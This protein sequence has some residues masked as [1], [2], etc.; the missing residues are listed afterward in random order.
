M[1]YKKTKPEP[2][3]CPV[4]SENVGVSWQSLAV[5][6]R[7]KHGLAHEHLLAVCNSPKAI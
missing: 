4:C 1:Q 7:T 5:H 2:R 6:V 3:M